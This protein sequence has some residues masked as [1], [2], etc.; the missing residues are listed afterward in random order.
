MDAP[1]ELQVDDSDF[2]QAEDELSTIKSFIDSSQKYAKH[3]VRG[4]QGE[5]ISNQ[6]IDA[7]LK[8]K[9]LQILKKK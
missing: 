5:P 6:D 7:L 1:K 2:H 8:Q 9:K 3:V 4:D